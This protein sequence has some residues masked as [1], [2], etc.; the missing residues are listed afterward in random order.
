[1]GIRVWARVVAATVAA[2][3]VTT[4]TACQAPPGDPAIPTGP[5]SVVGRELTATIPTPDG[6]RLQTVEFADARHGYAALWTDEPVDRG[7]STDP[8][9]WRY[10]SAVFATTDGGAT[11]IRRPDPRPPTPSPQM[12]TVDA[13]TVVLLAEPDGWYVS[14]DGGA[15]FGFRPG[16]QEP[17]ELDRRFH[18]GP[19]RLACDDGCWV[20]VN[21]TRV[22][23]GLTGS[24][25]GVAEGADR[26]W[27]AGV[28]DGAAQ[29]AV[30]G[31]GGQ[32][33]RRVD[34]PAQV[35]GGLSRVVLSVSPDGADV[36]LVGYTDP[37]AGGIGQRAPLR[38]KDV[39]VP[40]L[41]RWTGD[42]WAIQ[43]TAGRPTEQQV[44]YSVTAIGGGLAAVT[45]PG[46]LS[47]VDEAWHPTGMRPGPEYVTALP[48][49]TVFAPAPTSHVYYLGT[50]VDRAV[51]WVRLS[52]TG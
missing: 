29:A 37:A 44:P 31:D 35:A 13:Q 2:S 30:S 39:G 36:W 32:T 23:T 19:V 7:V 38:R 5:T 17:A 18:P 1:M 15:S 20:S 9:T 12:Y 26:L 34:V 11:W 46:G 51:T 47:L 25:N 24:V 48:D 6:Y 16:M 49:G 10:A 33:W 27:V 42:A 28:A 50:R 40:L 21:G 41:W 22:E 3:T 8:A 43:G 52:L 14:T 4:A 45:G